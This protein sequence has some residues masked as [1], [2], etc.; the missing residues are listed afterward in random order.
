MYVYRSM[1]V[2]SSLMGSYVMELSMWLIAWTAV[3]D[4][5][6]VWLRVSDCN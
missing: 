1:H 5:V 4:T 2:M 6:I 3:E